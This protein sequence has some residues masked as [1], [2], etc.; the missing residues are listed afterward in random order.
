MPAFRP[1]IEN[2]SNHGKEK[3]FRI[4]LIISFLVHMGILINISGLALL[5]NPGRINREL[6][7]SYKIN[8]SRL[9]GIHTQKRPPPFIPQGAQIGKSS[10]RDNTDK[11]QAPP[12]IDKIAL[13]VPANSPARDKPTGIKSPGVDFKKRITT[14]EIDYAKV[15]SPAYMNYYELIREKIRKCAYQNYFSSETGNVYA[16]FTVLSN[17]SLSNIK[18]IDAKTN[19]SNYLKETAKKSVYAATP[20]PAFP[21]ELDYPELSFNVVIAFEME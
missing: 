3:G 6:R 8:R 20:F 5:R 19:A 17:G 10:S 11:R 14:P 15:K 18:I 16:A 2:T 7:V 1:I 9:P 21:K 12:F 13:P 4:A